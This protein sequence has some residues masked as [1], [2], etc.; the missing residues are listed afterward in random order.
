MPSLSEYILTLKKCNPN[1][2]DK[3]LKIY[4]LKSGWQIAD[5]EKAFA[6]VNAASALVIP[7]AQVV[8][9][10][11]IIAAAA[12]TV[13][14]PPVPAAI[15]PVA[16][17]P[18][19][20]PIVAA[21]PI[22][23][24]VPS[25]PEPVAPPV[26][27]PI[28]APA[29]K[30]L[31]PPM[32]FD[33]PTASEISQAIKHTHEIEISVPEIELAP[34]PAPIRDPIPARPNAPVGVPVYVATPAPT[35]IPPPPPISASISMPSAPMNQA[36]APTP[37]PT[38]A[39]EIRPVPAPEPKP[40]A[41]IIDPIQQPVPISTI[42]QPP[43]FTQPEAPSVPVPPP[44][45]PVQTPPPPTPTLPPV[46]PPAAPQAPAANP[47]LDRTLRH[48]VSS[49]EI[50]KA[51]AVDAPV[52]TPAPAPAPAPMP[53]PPPM[54]TPAPEPVPAPISIA[55][56]TPIPTP[57]EPMPVSILQSVPIRTLPSLAPRKKFSDIVGTVPPVNAAPAIKPIAKAPIAPISPATF[58]LPGDSY[59]AAQEKTVRIAPPVPRRAASGTT[60]LIVWLSVL[61]FLVVLGI[62]YM[63]FVHGVFVFVSEP[64]E[65]SS[66]LSHLASEAN[67][68]DSAE[69][70]SHVYFRMMPREP[71]VESFDTIVSALRILRNGAAPEPL[72]L[73]S[74]ATSSPRQK[75]K[76]ASIN[77]F[78]SNFPLDG[79]FDMEIKGGY[80]KK[81]D[82]KW[83]AKGDYS[84]EGLN[85]K[86]D[87]ESIV[88]EGVRY[89]K[90]ISFPERFFDIHDIRDTWISIS[91]A[92]EESVAAALP[93][94]GDDMLSLADF[95]I[96]NIPAN[97]P[98]SLDKQIARLVS[99]ANE[100]GVISV[101]GEP[102]KI[103]Q[104]DSAWYKPKK[105]AYEYQLQA[106]LE[107]F[108]E[109]AEHANR[110]LQNEFGSETILGLSEEDKKELRSPQF[111]KFFEYFVKN[112]YLKMIVDKDGALIGLDVSLKL[113]ADDRQAVVSAEITFD[114]I[115]RSISID[116]PKPE[117]TFSDAYG[118]ISGQSKELLLL[119]SQVKTIEG[120][121]EEISK[122][123]AAHS[124]EVPDTLNG[125]NLPR[126]TF[127]TSSYAYK[128]TEKTSYLLSYQVVMP[129]PPTQ[130]YELPQTLIGFDETT[131][132]PS[133]T[134]LSMQYLKFVHG[135]NTANE[136]SLSL[137]GDASKRLD[138][139]KDRITNGLE[140]YIGMNI[141]KK[142]SDEDGVDDYE[143]LQK[144]SNPLGA[145]P[146]VGS[147]K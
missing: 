98:E 76:Q 11:P 32:S 88:R 64:I 124:G 133:G 45:T 139:D 69:Y 31:V 22:A 18:P 119:K 2:E 70:T 147:N 89:V 16:P 91:D 75:A 61:A 58:A 132:I 115:N 10:A 80:R 23:P 94:L 135:K 66:V 65:K 46:P 17:I 92:D 28:S 112:G 96:L 140:Q 20:E 84:G 126:L 29:P 90:A 106:S 87:V 111:A 7:Q 15:A 60:K 138:S 107:R 36:P 130:F 77:E 95:G 34:A 33:I 43:V 25:V 143:E 128:K 82:D 81:G 35:P 103:I 122:Y 131:A 3:V 93:W 6:D 59:A 39:P 8:P 105:V 37:A 144:G 120:I 136:R 116:V 118:K 110:A 57:V 1:A 9:V 47:Y 52:P 117:M 40:V 63:R 24:G 19:S 5:I 4:L 54:P 42:I 73:A 146:W 79:I 12:P 51:L 121:R 38:P 78:L 72:V 41:Q 134:G 123:Q 68:I 13:V 50:L 48:S 86:L 99:I 67:R 74:V 101:V 71:G 85:A 102:Q 109:F 44:P 125:M 97:A 62:G 14:P 21:A 26:P 56:P 27:A 53:T 145:G 142:D 141:T 127:A 100:D 114:S 137:E 30:P 104:S 49:A 108:I 55:I 83:Q 113:V 129:A